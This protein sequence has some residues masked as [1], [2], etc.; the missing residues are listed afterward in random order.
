MSKIRTTR[1]QRLSDGTEVLKGG[2][3]RKIRS[4][5]NHQLAN[6]KVQADGSQVA[7]TASGQRF[8][9]TRMK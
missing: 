1:S 4:P 5:L 9:M 2:D 3:L 8:K 6:S 7:E